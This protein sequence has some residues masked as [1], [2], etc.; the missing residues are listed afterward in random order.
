MAPPPIDTK[1][2]CSWC[3]TDPVYVAYHDEVWG[4]P[5]YGAK[6][7]FAKLILDG[8][9]A[10]LSWITILKRQEGYYN[11]FDGLDPEKMA[12]YTDKRLDKILLDK[13][14]IRN[15]LKVYAARTNAR[16]Y[17]RMAQEGIDFSEYLWAFVGGGPIVNTHK[18][19]SD[20]PTTSPESDAMSKALKKQ[21]FKFVGS[22]ICYA[23]M[24]AVGMINDH[25]VDCFRHQEV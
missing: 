10:G 22:T 19:R 24:Q 6:E 14:I 20:V 25:V 23:F 12:R 1:T 4:L 8:A 18:T 11:L 21:G 16:Q 13:R 15:R 7:L 3:G 5:E 17:V 2:R 9:Q